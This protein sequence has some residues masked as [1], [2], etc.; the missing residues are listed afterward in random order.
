MPARTI[1]IGDVH[2]CASAL[3][4]LLAAIAPAPDDTIITLGDYVNRGSD[5][6]LVLD[7]L[8][9]LAGECRLVPILGNHD[10]VFL[11]CLTGLDQLKPVL[12]RMGG[13]AT[14]ASYGAKK[15]LRAVPGP[16]I[17]FLRLCLPYHETESHVFLH[18]NYDPDAPWPRQ[19]VEQIR[20]TSLRET[21][22]PPH[23]SGKTVIVG[24][25]AQKSGEILDL[26][27]LKCIDA[28]CYGGGWLTALD[29]H[30]GRLWQFS[31]TGRRRTTERAG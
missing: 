9:T 23:V 4:A 19:R 17:E 14:L 16:H 24:H 2:G 13:E 3:E 22:P 28:F 5:S 10:Q 20:W 25:T 30:S 31:K 7:R 18:A 15:S 11:D 6:R 8:I 12:L 21:T 27:Y 29:V 26:G 1:A